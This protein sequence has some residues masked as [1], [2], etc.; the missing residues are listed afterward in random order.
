MV[1]VRAGLSP[2]RLMLA[3]AELTDEAGFDQVTLS[4]LARRFDVKPASLYAHVKNSHEL[5]TRSRCSHW[6]NSP[7]GSPTPWPGARAR[8]P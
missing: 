2:E 7:T 5:K 3:G 8:T 1:V 4:A 6:R